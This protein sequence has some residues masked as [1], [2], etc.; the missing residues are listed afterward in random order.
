MCGREGRTTHTGGILGN[1]LPPTSWITSRCFPFS[2]LEYVGRVSSS[3]SS[4]ASLGLGMDEVEESDEEDG[5][6]FAM[7][8]VRLGRA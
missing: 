6:G 1:G 7:V 4:S 5:L 2:L 3:S 8:Y